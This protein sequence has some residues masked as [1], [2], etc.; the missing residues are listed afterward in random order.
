LTKRSKKQ[1]AA[2]GVL[3]VLESQRRAL[4]RP[5]EV[6]APAPKKKAR[7]NPVVMSSSDDADDAEDAGPLT[8]SALLEKAALSKAERE[9]DKS[10][11]AIARINKRKVLDEER[12]VKDR[13]MREIAKRRR[14]ESASE[15]E[16]SEEEDAEGPINQDD[17]SD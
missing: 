6:V 13:L 15:N 12:G 11:R 16:D 9:Q 8:G 14:V 3:A 7:N 4:R 5:A 2:G 10:Q 1:R 17:S